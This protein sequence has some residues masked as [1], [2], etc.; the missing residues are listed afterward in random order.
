MAI[1][2]ANTPLWMKATLILLAIVFLFGFISIGA[3][4]FVDSGTA[5]PAAGTTDAI[6]QQFQPTVAALTA[7]LQSDPESYTALVN[8]GNTYFDWAIQTQQASQTNTATIGAEQPLW[9][10]AKDAYGRAVALNPDEPP[11]VVDY[12][13]TVFY[14]G[15]TNKAI[16]EVERIVKA[17][18]D[19]AP[20]FFNIGIFYGAL[21]DTAN[22]VASFKKYLE[23]DPNGEQGNAD[24]AKQEI[25]RLEGQAAPPSVP[26]T[27]AP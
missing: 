13:I 4:P 12:A 20:A 18:P 25:E 8:L 5:P 6:A 14:T 24:F 22:A 19:F 23:L 27:S 15:D 1:N 26:A 2:K 7:A 9:V 3:S 11:V 21:G 16:A 10:A 17:N